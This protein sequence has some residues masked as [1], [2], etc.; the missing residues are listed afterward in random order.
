M[1]HWHGDTFDLPQGAAL[2]ASTQE[3]TQ[4][5]FQWK[6][7]LAFQCHP[8]IRGRDFERWLIGH[9]VEIE[10]VADAS[11]AQLREQSASLAPVLAQKAARVFSDWL[12]T[13]P[14]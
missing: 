12:A 7:A 2:L 4:Q 14:A 1:L 13:V 11:V 3:V 10:A 6:N 8:E 5:I 9:A